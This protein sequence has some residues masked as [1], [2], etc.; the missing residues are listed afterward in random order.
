MQLAIAGALAPVADA[1]AVDGVNLKLTHLGDGKY[2]IDD[3]FARL[4]RPSGKPTS[5]PLKFALFNLALTNAAVDFSDKTVGKTHELRDLNFSVPFLSNLDSR[6]DVTT[7]PKLAFKLN[8]SRFD[9]DAQTTPFAQSHKTDASI[10]LAGVDLKPY[11]GY[12]PASVPV[13]LLA[14]VLNADIKVA[15]EQVSRPTVKLSGWCRR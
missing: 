6:R 13:R 15:F 2:D 9:S 8:G 5:E 12:V 10:R 11:L 1:V 7:E 4:N 3:I 14:A